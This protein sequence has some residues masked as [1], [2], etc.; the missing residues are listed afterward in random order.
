MLV[1]IVEEKTE[2]H[3]TQY[4]LTNEDIIQTIETLMYY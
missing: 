1:P 3:V 4:L 2:F